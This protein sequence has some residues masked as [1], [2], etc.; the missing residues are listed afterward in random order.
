VGHEPKRDVYDIGIVGCGVIGDRLAA[1]IDDHAATTVTAACDVDESRVTDFTDEYD[2]V[3]YTDHERLVEADLDAVYVGVPPAHHVAVATDALAAGHHVLCEK[4]IAP[5]AAGGERLTAAAAETDRVT[6]VNLP[7]RYTPGFREL[8]DRVANGGVGTVRRV[9]LRFRFPEWPREWQDV[10]WLE[11]REQGGPIREVGTHFLFGVRELF[12]PVERVTARVQYD[13]PERHERSVVGGFTVDGVDGTLDLATGV[14]ASEENSL[15]VL[16]TEGRL[17]LREWHRLVADDGEG[18]ERVVNEDRTS[19]TR[20]LL[21]EFVTAIDSH[22]EGS[23]GETS[24]AD[25][26]SFEEATAVQRVVDGVF[27]SE[28]EAVDPRVAGD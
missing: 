2:C 18:S 24:D 3:G 17:T 14:A 25:L 4:P 10:E 19:T 27:D 16:G 1:T 21:D 7:F 22:A 13:G 6:A 11:G 15:T 23:G 28:G 9:E 8:C 26:V 12:G 20:L 5:T